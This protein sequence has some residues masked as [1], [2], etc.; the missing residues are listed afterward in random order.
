[1]P[2]DV[3]SDDVDL[4]LSRI[5]IAIRSRCITVNGIHQSS[6]VIIQVPK[7]W[8]LVFRNLSNLTSRQS[9]KNRHLALVL[10]PIRAITPLLLGR[11][12][13]QRDARSVVEQEVGECRGEEGQV[14]EVRREEGSSAGGGAEEGVATDEG[15]AGPECDLTG[16]AVNAQSAGYFHIPC[17]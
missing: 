13:Q 12:L 7:Q 6:S 4:I 17:V 16:V 14:R 1:M 9:E 2:V 8:T 5:P 10:F 3:K 15:E 11:L